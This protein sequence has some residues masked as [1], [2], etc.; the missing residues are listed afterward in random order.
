MKKNIF[1][2]RILSVDI[3]AYHGWKLDACRW[4]RVHSSEWLTLS[5][6]LHIQ[7]FKPSHSCYHHVLYL[8]LKNLLNFANS[9]TVTIILASFS[10]SWTLCWFV[11]IKACTTPHALFCGLWL[12]TL[13][14]FLHQVSSFFIILDSL[15]T[16]NLDWV[17]LLAWPILIALSRVN[18]R[19]CNAPS[20]SLWPKSSLRLVSDKELSSPKQQNQF[21]IMALA[22]TPSMFSPP[23]TLRT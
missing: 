16:L 7:R 10:K 9:C 5:L 22:T 15:F 20:L 12:W 23:C 14:A 21:Y 11:L 17:I 3:W 6:Q 2:S 13:C 8:G 19:S 1:F 18:Y 4:G